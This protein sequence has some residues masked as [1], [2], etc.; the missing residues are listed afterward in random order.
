M[1]PSFP[2]VSPD[3]H[4]RQSSLKGYEQRTVVDPSARNWSTRGEEL[5][6]SGNLRNP[7]IDRDMPEAL[8]VAV[9]KP[10]AGHDE[11]ILD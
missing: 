5:R 7:L 6:R 2:T 9:T 10:E 1:G 11:A 8:P 4:R 3:E